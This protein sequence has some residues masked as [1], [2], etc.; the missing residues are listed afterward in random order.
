MVTFRNVATV[1]VEVI[2]TAPSMKERRDFITRTPS[3]MKSVL[4]DAASMTYRQPDFEINLCNKHFYKVIKLKK[5]F[6]LI[7]FRLIV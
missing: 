4:Q 3:S 1:D 7:K 6:L 2:I 5:Y